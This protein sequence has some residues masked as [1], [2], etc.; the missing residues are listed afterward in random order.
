[1]DRAPVGAPM[2]VERVPTGVASVDRLLAGGLEPDGLT[3]FYGEGGSGKTLLCLQ[4]ATR[5]ALSD[6]WVFYVDTEGVSV[7]RLESIA[8]GRVEQVLKRMLLST[9]KDLAEQ[10]RAVAKA[11]ALAR[12]GKRPVGL[13]V[14]DSATFYYRLTLSGGDEDEGRQALGFELGDLLSTALHAQVPVIFTNQVWRN[15]RDG[16]LEPLGG[17]FVN[18]AAK[19]ILRFDRLPGNRRRVV[20]VK[21]RSLGEAAAE[22][23]ITPTGLDG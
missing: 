14:L 6:R 13:I 10:S 16:T 5:V 2:P 21:H 20:L 3:E 23:R 17:S 15:Q 7:D 12:E 11:C 9:P 19:T 8:A 4:V 22:F 1:M 18:H